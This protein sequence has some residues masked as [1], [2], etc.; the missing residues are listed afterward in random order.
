MN[1]Q[2]RRALERKKRKA[3]NPVRAE[4]LEPKKRKELNPVHDKHLKTLEG[5]LGKPTIFRDDAG[6]L[7]FSWQRENGDRLEINFGDDNHVG[8]HISTDLEIAGGGTK[9]EKLTILAEAF[10]AGASG[11]EIIQLIQ[12]G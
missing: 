11:I 4:Y 12:L 5:I 10:K 9:A 7:A 2:Q 3:S 6:D 1:R 8:Y